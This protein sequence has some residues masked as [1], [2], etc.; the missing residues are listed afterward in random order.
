MNTERTPYDDEEREVSQMED[1]T[2]MFHAP[3]MTNH[4]QAIIIRWLEAERV[5]I[6]AEAEEYEN[7]TGNP[8]AA[9]RILAQGD[10]VETLI[11]RVAA[12]DTSAPAL[13]DDE[14]KAQAAGVL[15]KMSRDGVA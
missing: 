2:P 5:R 6:I 9:D 15:G 10:Y 1:P 4:E 14:R 12:L 13:T 11:A 3:A 7:R 8:Y